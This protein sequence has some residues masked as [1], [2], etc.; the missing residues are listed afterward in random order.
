LLILPAGLLVRYR[1]RPGRDQEAAPEAT[2]LERALAL[3]EWARGRSDAGERRGAL[4]ALA[5]ELQ[6]ERGELADRVRE[7][8]WSRVPPSPD[9]MAELL[10]AVRENDGDD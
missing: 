9:E 6:A 4:E 8:A 2:P 7:Q 1:R 3:V 5:L 10:R